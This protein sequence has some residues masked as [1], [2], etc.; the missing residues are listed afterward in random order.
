MNSTLILLVS[1]KG[2]IKT[3]VHTRRVSYEKDRITG[4]CGDRT[5]HGIRQSK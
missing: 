1:R 4:V 2:R 5:Y 3:D